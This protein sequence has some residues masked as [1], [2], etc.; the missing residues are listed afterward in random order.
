MTLTTEAAGNSK[1][2]ARSTLR[3]ADDSDRSPSHELPAPGSPAEREDEDSAWP[4]GGAP[5]V[6]ANPL[7]GLEGLPLQPSPGERSGS[8]TTDETGPLGSGY[9]PYGGVPATPAVRR[10]EPRRPGWGGVVAVG[11]GAA[12]LSSLLT[13]GTVHAFG[14]NATATGAVSSTQQS[15]PLVASTSGTPNWG[16][17]AAAVQP[18]VVSVQVTATDGSSGQGSGVILDA[19]GR[20]LTNNHVVAAAGTGGSFSVVLSDGRT[21]PATVVGTDPS[22]DLAVIQINNAPSGLKP[23]TFG[24]SATV[25]VGDPVMAIGNPLG[26]SDTVTTG[27][28]SA[29]NRPVAASPSDQQQSPSGSAQAQS[30]QAVTDAIQ[31]DAAINPGNSGGALVDSGGRIIGIT[32]SIASLGSSTGTQP[33]SIGLGFAIPANEA[34]DV[35]DQLLTTGTVQHA[36]LGLTLADGSV[37][38]SGAQQQAAVVGAVSAGTPAATAGLQAKDAVIAMNG[39]PLNSADSLVAQIRALRPGTKITLTIVRGGQKQDLTVTL[40]ARPAG[41]SG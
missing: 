28:I 31:T 3:P 15:A 19:Q 8:P 36:Y 18:S 10:G 27:I 32:S 5:S 2:G 9:P 38:V 4:L 34:K 7:P 13:A 41:G 25:K 39:R 35:A 17:V 21:Y 1:H 14:N 24:D 29:L 12:I 37:S 22:T 26:L 40:A 20:I 6:S 16:S 30:E 33:G 23:A 11:A